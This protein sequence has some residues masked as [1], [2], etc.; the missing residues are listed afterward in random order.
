VTDILKTVSVD[1][2][3]DRCGDFTVGADVIAESQRLLAEGCPGSSYECPPSLLATLL[4]QSVLESLES[5]WSELQRATRSPVRQLSFDD[6]PRVASANDRLDPRSISRWED[7][8]GYIP[9]TQRARD[10]KASLGLSLREK[11]TL[12]TTADEAPAAR[13]DEA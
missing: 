8:G 5:A 4:P 10:A 3:C 6:S 11:P 1:V 7:D 13:E 2:H 12:A 9:G